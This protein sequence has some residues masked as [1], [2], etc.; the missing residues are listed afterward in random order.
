MSIVYIYIYIYIY[1][2]VCVCVCVCVRV[3]VR[4]CVRACVCACV[5]GCMRACVCR[6]K[7]FK[8]FVFIYVIYFSD[9]NQN[10]HQ[11]LCQS[12]VSH[13]PSGMIPIC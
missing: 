7:D 1:I 4:A 10:F 13:N 8:C 5:H 9:A 2:R 11:L 12:S 6:S 3:C